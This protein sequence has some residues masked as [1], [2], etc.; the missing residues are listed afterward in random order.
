MEAIVNVGQ[1]LLAED[2]IN[3]PLALLDLDPLDANPANVMSKLPLMPSAIRRLDSAI[4]SMGYMVASVTDACLGIGVSQ[5]VN[6][7]SAMAMQ[8]IVTRTVD[9]A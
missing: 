7:A 5:A 9:N 3:V 6:P 4:V 2:A 8:M 1:M